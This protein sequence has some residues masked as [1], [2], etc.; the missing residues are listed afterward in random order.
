MPMMMT[1]AVFVAV[2][3]DAMLAVV[4]KS[5]ALMSGWRQMARVAVPTCV[6]FASPSRRI[7]SWMSM[8]RRFVE[9]ML[10]FEVVGEI[11][12]LRDP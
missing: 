8:R 1:F 2:V 6:M 7:M 3:R 4:L 11:V 5:T 9:G 12:V 10:V